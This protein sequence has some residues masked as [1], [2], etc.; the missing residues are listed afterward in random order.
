MTPEDKVIVS[1]MNEISDLLNEFGLTLS[2]Y[3]PGISAFITKESTS[4]LNFDRGEWAW[5]EPLLKELKD[6]RERE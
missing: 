5:L 4:M 6:R 2:G 1:R 3:D